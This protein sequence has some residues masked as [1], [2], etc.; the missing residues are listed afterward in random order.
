VPLAGPDFI[1]EDG[2]IK[3]LTMVDGQPLLYRTLLSR[4]WMRPTGDREAPV[5]I[6]VL[7][8]KAG[9]RS[10]ADT[11]LRDWFPDSHFCFISDVTAGAAL[12]ALAAMAMVGD[13][14]APL[15]LDLADIGFSS[16]LDPL[17]MFAQTPDLGGVA[18]TFAADWPQYSY[19]ELDSSGY[20]SRAREKCVIST[21]ASAGVYFFASVTVYLNAVAHL[22]QNRRELAYRDLLFVC[23]ALNG[24]VASGLRVKA[25]E[26]THVIDIKR[27]T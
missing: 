14:D 5:M 7:Q 2:S 25:V 16:D 18:L 12:S 1:A 27:L 10:F 3:A 6:F 8:D 19:L 22:I 24:V 9:T 13:F 21:H 17:A 20:M 26:C 23:P 4:P 11:Y 15:C